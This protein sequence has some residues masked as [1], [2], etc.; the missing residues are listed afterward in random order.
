MQSVVNK[1]EG[2]REEVRVGR[3]ELL[4]RAADDLHAMRAERCV[5][6]VY[7]SSRQFLSNALRRLA[8]VVS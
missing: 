7:L 5:W 6:N 3:D 4:R 1:F 8:I 2:L